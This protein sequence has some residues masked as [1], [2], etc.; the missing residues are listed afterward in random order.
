MQKRLLILTLYVASAFITSLN[1]DTGATISNSILSTALA[2]PS[3]SLKHLSDDERKKLCHE[4]MTHTIKSK[5]MLNQDDL[6]QYPF[7]THDESVVSQ[8][9]QRLERQIPVLSAHATN[10][11]TDHALLTEGAAYIAAQAGHC[12]IPVPQ[13]VQELS[14]GTVTDVKKQLES[15]H[16]TI[17]LVNEKIDSF[18][19]DYPLIEKLARKYGYNKFASE[20][21]PAILPWVPFTINAVL[22]GIPAVA[23]YFSIGRFA[24][25]HPTPAN[26]AIFGAATKLMVA[27]SVL[28][29]ENHQ[30]DINAPLEQLCEAYIKEPLSEGYKFAQAQ[31]QLKKRIHVEGW[32]NSQSSVPPFSELKGIDPQVRTYIEKMITNPL[33]NPFEYYSIYSNHKNAILFVG[34]RG[35]GKSTLMQAIAQE[36][37]TLLFTIPPHLLSI[38]DQ[39]I[40]ALKGYV[41]YVHEE[42]IRQN[43][44][45]VVLVLDEIDC[46]GMAD[47]SNPLSTM[48]SRDPET[49]ETILQNVLTF[50]DGAVIPFEKDGILTVILAA[51]NTLHLD[52]AVTRQGRLDGIISIPMPT[53]TMRVEILKDLIPTL[54][55]D[56]IDELGVLTKGLS[57][58][59]IKDATKIAAQ[60]ATREN[61]KVHQ[62]HVVDAI[63]SIKDRADNKGP[64][65]SAEPLAKTAT[66]SQPSLVVKFN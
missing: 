55:Q 37:N 14:Q 6:L 38:K 15:L 10:K 65:K 11:N 60:H 21:L 27:G 66:K 1:A 42:A 50:L 62:T 35:T 13:E 17:H 45:S 28:F 7:S 51:A 64:V 5:R 33:K 32:A 56:E 22:F 49:A 39:G 25:T 48:A 58:A 43:K 18:K 40:D 54:E 20:Q 31:A 53:E 16:T 44:T 9:K 52:P 57:H 47:T 30:R 24:R 19:P 26:K 3:A 59:D 41:K 4:F 23:N 8:I 34:E 63:Q 2:T 61:K 12:D 46:L 29:Y 36:A